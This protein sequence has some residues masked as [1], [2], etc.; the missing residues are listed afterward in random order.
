MSKR[1]DRSIYLLRENLIEK[2]SLTDWNP[3]RP[4]MYIVHGWTS[5]RLGEVN[6]EVASAVL[7]KAD[8]NIIIVDWGILA[9]K[10]Y[11]ESRRSVFYVAEELA[12]FISTTG[13]SPDLITI[14]GHSLGAHVSAATSRYLNSSIAQVV[15]LDPAAPLFGKRALRERIHATDA[16]IVHIIHTCGGYLGLLSPIGIADFYPDGGMPAY[17]PGCSRHGIANEMICAHSRAY[18]LYAES[19]RKG[20]FMATK[21]SSIIDFNAGVCVNN[22]ISYMG[23]LELDSRY[24][25]TLVLKGEGMQNGY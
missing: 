11:T 3:K 17:Q 13:Q 8:W 9:D 5:N 1:T 24:V 23:G 12:K 21:C 22:S 19:I 7:S 18:L 15:G 6:L 16:K 4:T 14:V 20:G 10:L 25:T 2:I